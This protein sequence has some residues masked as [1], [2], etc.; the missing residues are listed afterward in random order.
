MDT[1]IFINAISHFSLWLYYISNR[2]I[3]NSSGC[4]NLTSEDINDYASDD[5]Y[6]TF[7]IFFN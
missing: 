6:D 4:V 3:S 5:R 1:D 7:S 2:L